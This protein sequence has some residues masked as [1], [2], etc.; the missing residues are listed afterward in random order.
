MRSSRGEQMKQSNQCR[1]PLPATRYPHRLPDYLSGVTF[2]L[3]QNLTHPAD[4]SPGR[5][6]TAVERRRAKAR[7][8]EAGAGQRIIIEGA[9]IISA[10]LATA[11]TLTRHFN[12]QFTCRSAP[13]TRPGPAVPCPALKPILFR[14]DELQ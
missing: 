14:F 9:S 7:R 10:N 2:A 8:G 5:L 6:A 12:S 11:P 4:S 3:F 13:H 1:Y